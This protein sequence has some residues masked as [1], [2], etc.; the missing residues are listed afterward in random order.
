MMFET[1]TSGKYLSKSSGITYYDIALRIGTALNID[2]ATIVVYPMTA[3]IS[4]M[5]RVDDIITIKDVHNTAK[6]F[7]EV[8]KGDLSR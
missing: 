5:D 1:V 8:D 6:L 2:P 4:A 3:N 7:R